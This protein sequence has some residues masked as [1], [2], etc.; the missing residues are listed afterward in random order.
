MEQTTQE[1]Q[2][3]TPPP[4]P[5]TWGDP[6]LAYFFLRRPSTFSG[7]QDGDGAPIYHKGPPVGVVAVRYHDGTFR[8]SASLCSPSD[9]WDRARGIRSAIGRT[10]ENDA[11]RIM[12]R[13]SKETQV[14]KAEWISIPAAPVTEGHDLANALHMLH[15]PYVKG[16]VDMEQAEI[17]FTYIRKLVVERLKDSDG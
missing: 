13:V 17:A 6:H 10:L 8:V 11:R 5:Y 9:T 7:K 14:L 2:P 4:N 15:I 1:T 3:K 16:G 12:D